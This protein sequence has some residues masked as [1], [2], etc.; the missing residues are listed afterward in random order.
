MAEAFQVS[1][2]PYFFFLPDL[3]NFTEFLTV[4]EDTHK[5]VAELKE[6]GKYKLSVTTFSSSGSCEVRGSQLSKT[7]SF[8]ISKYFNKS[9]F[10][11]QTNMTLMLYIYNIMLEFDHCG[12]YGICFRIRRVWSSG[13]TCVGELNILQICHM[14]YLPWM[15]LHCAVLAELR[16]ESRRH[17]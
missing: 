16:T 12:S 10:F 15:G 11:S 4:S 8:Y 5:F 6:P 7:L 1:I 2:N 3:E 9:V 17:I 14:L 13:I